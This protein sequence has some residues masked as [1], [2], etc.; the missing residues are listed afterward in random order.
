MKTSC[1]IFLIDKNNKILMVHSTNSRWNVWG[2]PKGE[3]EPN[4]TSLETAKR[5]FLEETNVDISKLIN[6]CDFEYVYLG[7]QIYKSRQKVLHGHLY[8]FQKDLSGLEFKC[9][10]LIRES[11]L[12]EVDKFKWTDVTESLKWLHDAQTVLLEKYL[13]Q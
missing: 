4:E 11:T 5:E 10:S 9:T 12:P 2:I 8:K 7:E 13:K 3:P 6:D 1:G